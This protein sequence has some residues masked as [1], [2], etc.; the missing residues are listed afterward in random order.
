MNDTVLAKR[1]IDVLVEHLGKVDTE[2]FITM[3][4]REPFDY[5]EWQ[6][7]LFSG[8]GGEELYDAVMGHEE[9]KS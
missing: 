6:K 3:I 4:L 5:T 7:D 2:R 9:V 1:G 8:M